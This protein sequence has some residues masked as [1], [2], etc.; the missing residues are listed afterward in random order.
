MSTL[1]PS[2]A[3]PVSAIPGIVA[4]LRASYDAGVMR[5]LASRR[6]QLDQLRRML[7]EQEDKILAAL[8]IDLNKAPMEAYAT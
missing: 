4:E 5:S 8:E 7:T 2:V 3:A 6:T 1:E